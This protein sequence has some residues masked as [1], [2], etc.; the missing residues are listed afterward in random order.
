T[1]PTSM[2]GAE[3][4]IVIMIASRA[5]SIIS[6]SVISAPQYPVFA[7]RRRVAVLYPSDRRPHDLLIS[8]HHS[9]A[10]RKNCI[11]RKF[12]IIH[13]LQDIRHIRLAE[14]GIGGG[15]FA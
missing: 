15:C 13:G 1:R 3:I 6:A 5:K 8:L 7:M 11:Q 12:R 14:Q 4:W 9:V 2:T 10:Y